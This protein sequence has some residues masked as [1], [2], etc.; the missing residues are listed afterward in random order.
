[1]FADLK[2]SHIALAFEIGVLSGKDSSG[3][4]ACDVGIEGFAAPDTARGDRQRIKNNGGELRNVAMD[5]P[6]VRALRC[7]GSMCDLAH[8]I[9]PRAAVLRKIFPSAEIG[10][11]RLDR[12]A[13]QWTQAY[14]Q[15]VGE[16][17]RLFHDD[18]APDSNSSPR[19]SR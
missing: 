19:S 9:A 2:R 1:V 11:V 12:G 3:R 14:R 5:E 13:H 15:P 17:L 10:A 4:Q 16:T 18:I 6:L 7:L 8:D